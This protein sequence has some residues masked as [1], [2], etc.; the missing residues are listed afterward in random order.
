MELALEAGAE[1]F[2][3]A[4]DHFEITTDPAS[5]EVVHKKIEAAGIKCDVA[6]VTQIAT[7]SA[8]LNDRATAGVVEKLIEALEDHDDVKELHTNAE[9]SG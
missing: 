9:F 1:D 4:D 6:E 2:Q 8:P 7:L 3:A 5:F